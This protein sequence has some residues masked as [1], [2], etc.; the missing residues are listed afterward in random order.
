MQNSKEVNNIQFIE[1]PALH[2]RANRYI[3]IVIDVPGV[4]ESWRRSL[5]SFEWLRP[6][7]EIKDLPELPAR[8]QP[9]RAAVE[10]KLETGMPIEQPVLGIG[11]ME[12]VEIGIGRAEFLTLAARGVTRMPVHI[13]ASNESDFKAFR[14]DVSF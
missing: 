4:L 2:G 1:N 6:D 8:E 11:L 9:K 7:G 12:N 10:Q 13:P 14:A 3:C 5:F